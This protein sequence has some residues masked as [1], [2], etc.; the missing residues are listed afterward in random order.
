MRVRPSACEVELD[1]AAHRLQPRAMQVLVALGRAAGDVVSRD[2]LVRQCWGGTVVG[3][4]AINRVVGL[5]RRLAELQPVQFSIDTIPRIGYRLLVSPAAAPASTDRQPGGVGQSAP[6][7]E[8]AAPALRVQ[9]PEEAETPGA[10]A[11][12]LDRLRAWGR[13]LL[14]RPVTLAAVFAA[15]LLAATGAVAGLAAGGS[16]RSVVVQAPITIAVL[17]FD[18]VGTA[19]DPD[20][21]SSFSSELHYVF[22]RSGAGPRLIARSSSFAFRDERK[23]L[24]SIVAVLDVTH[25]LD[26]TIRREGDTVTVTAELVEADSGR[27]IWRERVSGNLAGLDSLAIQLVKDAREALRVSTSDFG[28]PAS[29][30][31]EALDLYFSTEFQPGDAHAE[32]QRAA[33]L[34]LRRAVEIEPDFTRA[35]LKLYRAYE[36]YVLAA[37]TPEARDEATLGMVDAANTLVRIAPGD[38]E[39][40]VA[41]ARANPDHPERGQYFEKARQLDPANFEVQIF[42]AYEYFWHGR[43]VR[44]TEIAEAAMALN[45]LDDRM[46]WAMLKGRFVTGNV[47]AAEAMLATAS[48]DIAVDVWPSAI[49]SR[50]VNGQYAEAKAGIKSFELL[51]GTFD[52][53]ADAEPARAKAVKRRLAEVRELLDV[54]DQRPRSP[55]RAAELADRFTRS[56]MAV[57]GAG[58]GELSAGYRIYLPGIALLSGP[59]AAVDVWARRMDRIL[60]LDALPVYGGLASREYEAWQTSVFNPSARPLWR[61]PRFWPISRRI[62]DVTPGRSLEGWIADRRYWPADFCLE[63]DMPYDCTRAARDALEARPSR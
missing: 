38:A 56:A 5:I 16:D 48:P 53:D 20:F 59:E 42:E 8:P 29:V 40:W 46:I 27:Q 36:W 43:G 34:A 3:D 57:D 18:P 47:G 49:M 13:S 52:A 4:D 15:G 24:A 54:L 23:D 60:T 21:A 11:G 61:D 1:G 22:S 19:T 9:L 50:I 14:R 28:A 62:L 12:P 39:S 41:M 31:P 58:Y 32:D 10:S 35:W 6:A 33:I 51:A 26:G 7:P 55:A 25:V 2:E 37:P 63:P 30:D 44:G 17:S 45:P